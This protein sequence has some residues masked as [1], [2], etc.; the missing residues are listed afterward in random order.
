M[1][2]TWLYRIGWLDPR[3]DVDVGE[4]VADVSITAMIALIFVLFVH[5]LRY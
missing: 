4:V 3:G 5:V 1:I 2:K